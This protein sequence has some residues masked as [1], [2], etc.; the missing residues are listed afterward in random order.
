M[1]ILM[2]IK[3][4]EWLGGGCIVFIEG[5]R[6]DLFTLSARVG[7]EKTAREREQN[8]CQIRPADKIS[9][10]AVIRREKMYLACNELNCY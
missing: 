10:L 6:L 9:E 1:R 3:V 7:E 2:K 5:G 4:A 8:S